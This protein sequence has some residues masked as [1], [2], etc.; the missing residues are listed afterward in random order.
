M[1]KLYIYRHFYTLLENEIRRSVRYKHNISL[2]MMD[3]D[4][5]KTIN[6]TYGHAVGDEMLNAVGKV[7]KDNT[8]KTDLVGRYGGDEFI[9]LI[10]DVPSKEVAINIAWKIC[11]KVKEIKYKDIQNIITVSIGVSYT[12]ESGYNYRLL[13]DIADDR[14]YIAK[15]SGKDKV[16]SE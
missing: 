15:R 8:R 9:A 7:L 16:I 11:E 4:D 12:G 3:I 2:L 10:H 1:T 13:K 6:D 5:F 14:L